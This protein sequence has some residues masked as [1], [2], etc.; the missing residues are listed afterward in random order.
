[1]AEIKFTQ[2]TVYEGIIA[3]AKGEETSVPMDEIVALAEKK[4]EQLARKTA[5]GT[6]KKNG[7]H[8]AFMEIIRDILSEKNKA[9]CGEILKDTRVASFEW[10]DGKETSSQRVSAILRKMIENGDVVKSTEKKDTYFAL[11]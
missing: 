1:M 2:K 11:V 5:N 3:L 6:A 4:I 9:K 10:A 8:E 7:E